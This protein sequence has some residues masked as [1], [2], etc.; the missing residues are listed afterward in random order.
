MLLTRLQTARTDAYVYVLVYFFVFIMAIPVDGV[1][2]DFSISSVEEVQPQLWS[3]LLA[4][5]VL[6]QIPKMLPEDSKVVIVGVTRM[7]M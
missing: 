5:V 7:L 1:G 2:P 4:N 6:P 3:Q